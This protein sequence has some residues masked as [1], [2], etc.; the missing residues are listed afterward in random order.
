MQKKPKKNIVQIALITHL[1]ALVAMLDFA[2]AASLRRPE[3]HQRAPGP[4]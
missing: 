3:A 2:P 1:A 4:R